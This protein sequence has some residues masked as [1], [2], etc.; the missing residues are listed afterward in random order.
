VLHLP[1]IL[2]TAYRQIKLYGSCC[3]DERPKL[4]DLLSKVGGLSI[5]D[6]FA[7]VCY[8]C[9]QNLRKVASKEKELTLL[10]ELKSNEFGIRRMLVYYNC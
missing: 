2:F 5:F 10:E 6:T 4:L 1:F 8:G 3:N 7:Q 9:N